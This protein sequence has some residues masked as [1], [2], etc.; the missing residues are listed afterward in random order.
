MS[1]EE[2]IKT[3]V[4]FRL[5]L[6]KRLKEKAFDERTS[7]TEVLQRLAESWVA[8]KDMRAAIEKLEPEDAALVNKFIKMLS[9]RNADTDSLNSIRYLLDTY[10]PRNPGTTESASTKRKRKSS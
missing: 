10:E 6:L 2:T 3:S 8:E 5:A 4:Y 9:D 1:T 7:V